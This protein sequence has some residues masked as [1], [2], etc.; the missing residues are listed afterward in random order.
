MLRH[1]VKILCK[2][3]KLMAVLYVDIDPQITVPA[4]LLTDGI[5]WILL[6]PMFP[7]NYPHNF[8][9]T[10]QVMVHNPFG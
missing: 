5:Y 6:Y 10:S 4:V 3:E 9:S 7:E 1:S 2:L 8:V